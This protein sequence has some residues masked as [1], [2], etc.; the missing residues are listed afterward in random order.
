MKRFTQAVALSVS[1]AA[2]MTSAQANLVRETKFINFDDLGVSSGNFYL[3]DATHQYY[4]NLF[5]QAGVKLTTSVNTSPTAA[6][7]T[8]ANV[9]AAPSDASFT[10][11]PNT[12]NQSPLL[13]FATD[14]TFT[15]VSNLPGNPNKALIAG[16]GFWSFAGEVGSLTAGTSGGANR[17]FNG[18][19][20]NNPSS[21]NGWCSEGI[22]DFSTQSDTDVLGP[23][24]RGYKSVSLLGSAFLDAIA[25]DLVY[26]DGTCSTPPCNGGGG[27]GG[28]LP[29]PGSIALALAALAG[30]SVVSHRRKPAKRA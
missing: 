3:F 18:C 11:H 23:G 15:A 21:N 6:F 13:Q 9:A 22:F 29:E 16:I 17:S 4:Q 8:D 25:I 2:L 27:G 1:L 14:L 19:P 10:G 24:Y 30:S 20:S 12:N 28:G 5:G 26:D 7:A